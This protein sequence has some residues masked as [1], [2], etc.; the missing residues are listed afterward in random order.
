MAARLEGASWDAQRTVKR[1]NVLL[2]PRRLMIA[3]AAVGCKRMLGMRQID[4][5]AHDVYC[6]SMHRTD[7][8]IDLLPPRWRLSPRRPKL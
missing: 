8:A 1:A 4:E 3:P 2:Q 6:P 5:V 7:T